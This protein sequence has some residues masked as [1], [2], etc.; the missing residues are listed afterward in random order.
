MKPEVIVNNQN[1]MKYILLDGQRH[2]QISWRINPEDAR[3]STGYAT[4][5]FVDVRE[6]TDRFYSTVNVRAS[7]TTDFVIPLYPTVLA[8]GEEN[9]IIFQSAHPVKMQK[10][11]TFTFSMP[12]TLTK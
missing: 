2:L 10:G 11:D 3:G 9:A 7:V 4:V 8:N 5:S 12:L 6:D 1:F